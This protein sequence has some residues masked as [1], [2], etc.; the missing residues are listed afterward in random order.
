MFEFFAFRATVK[1]QSL[2]AVLL[3]VAV[4]K[5]LVIVAFATKIASFA[6]AFRFIFAIESIASFARKLIDLKRIKHSDF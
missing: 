3:L 4:I 1:M 2:I 6:F 5:M